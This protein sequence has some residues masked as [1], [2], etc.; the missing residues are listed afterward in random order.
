MEHHNDLTFFTNEPDR[1]LYDRFSKIL[2]SNTK[3]FDV[4]VGYFRTSGFYLM[5]PAMEDIEN[6]RILVGLNVDGKTVQIIQKSKEEQLSFEMSHKEVKGEF[7]DNIQ[8]EMENSEDSFKVE[9]GIKIFIK[10]LQS[11]KLQMRIFPESPIHAKVYI[12][13]K[14][15]NKCPDSYGSVI[16]GSSNFSQAGL[17]NNLEFNVELKDSR[18][19]DFALEKFEELWSRSIDITEEYIETINK[20]TWIR[21]DITPYELFLK[22]LYEYFKEEINEDKNDVWVEML[23]ENFMKLQYQTDAVIQAKKTLDSY[24]GVFISDVV[25]LGKTYICAM[26]M[27]RLKGRKLVICPP[28]LKDYWE[29]TLHQFEVSAEVESLG[30]LDDIIND[31]DIMKNTRYVFIDE[32]HR[33]RNGK[34]ESFQ[35]LHEICYNKKVVLI[36]ATPQNNFSTDIANQIYLFQ[37][38]NNSTII[39]ND[40][41]LEAFFNKLDSQL[42]KLERGTKEYS[43]KLKAN[44]EIIR[45]QVLRNVMIRR[46][47]KEITEFYKDDLER[48]GLRFPQLST[49]EKIVYI[50]KDE[51]E[52]V[53]NYTISVIKSMNYSRYQPLTYLKKID[54]DIAS[55]MVSQKN[56]GGFMKSILIKRLESSFE[57]FKKTLNRFIKSYEQ[58]IDMCSKGDVYISKKIDV[59]DLLD[60]GDDEKLMEFVDEDRVQHY[61]TN[62]FREDFISALKQDLLFLKLLQDQW[63]E[64]IDDPKKEQFLLEL[65]NNKTLKNKKIIIFTE[66]KETAEYIG[67]YLEEKYP[68]KVLAFS[69]QGSRHERDEIEANFNPNYQGKKK[70]DIQYLITTDVLAE[71]INLHRANIIVNYDLPWNPTK[72]MQRVGRINRVGTE[73]DRIYVF[74]FFPAAQANAELSMEE[75]IILKIQAFHD[76][77]GEDFKYLSEDEEVSSHKLYQKLNSNDIFD[78]SDV[79]GESELEYLS[80]IRK[81]RDT[82]EKLF[83]KVKKLPKKSKSSRRIQGIKS[84]VTLSFLR[85]GSLKKFYATDGQKIRELTFIEA[86]KYLKCTQEEKKLKVQKEYFEHL[87]LNKEKF[88]DIFDE[89]IFVNTTNATKTTGND[90]KIIKILKGIFKICKAFTDEQEKK[91]KQLQELW[92]DGNI[93]ASISKEVVKVT[94]NMNDPIKIYYEIEN[95]VPEN[96]FEKREN[97][98]KKNIEGNIKVILSEY[99]QRG[100]E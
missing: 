21:D 64:I 1:N 28:V 50:Y 85:K 2:K 15:M 87:K 55:Q 43:D 53:F 47:R 26:L 32:A 70:D 51:I 30:K 93:P 48:Q 19:V 60:N 67:L 79:Y 82:D 78:E 37:P 99:L 27:Q 5:Y 91:I 98:Q 92:E 17:V 83:E 12:M 24:D 41:N 31:N 46:T 57:A 39:P 100:E 63:E 62:E 77:L 72:I 86:M 9:Q 97:K 22:T 8:G 11:G 96:Y 58:F 40:K 23:P 71:G 80:L 75:N 59:Y 84:S 69:G 44:S 6:I 94:K 33:F 65:E 76:T 20:D 3:F 95:L 25:G 16:T 14:D 10:W 52:K 13:R 56:M 54:K 36:T 38:K 81:I 18:D 35:K 7:K 68:E 34:T 29:K 89:E 88:E 42:K 45:D 73:H 61:K 66:S 4:L 49:P 74:N 90:A